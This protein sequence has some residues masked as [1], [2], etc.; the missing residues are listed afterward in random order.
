MTDASVL[1]SS[2]HPCDDRGMGKYLIRDSKT[3]ERLRE[4]DDPATPKGKNR[5]DEY[6][7]AYPD[8]YRAKLDNWVA[9]Q[10][11]AR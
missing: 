11:K 9:R 10:K 8:D 5:D 4:T 7:D 3:H 6:I 2:T 1:R